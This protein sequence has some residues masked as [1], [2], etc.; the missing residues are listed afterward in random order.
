MLKKPLCLLALAFRAPL[1]LLS[2]PNRSCNRSALRSGHRGERRRHAD[3]RRRNPPRRH[4]RP[5]AD[6]NYPV[7]LT[8]TPYNKDNFAS[9]GQKGAA[10]GF[11]VVV[12]DVRGRF[13]SDGEWYPFKHEI[14]DGYDTVEW[15]AALPHSNSKVGMF[16]GSYVGA[17]QMLAAIGHPPHLAGICPVVTASNY[18]ENWTYQAAHSSS[19]ST[20]HG[21]QPWPKTRSTA[22]LRKRTMR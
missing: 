22:G 7:L 12:Q 19:G 4:L 21:P 9:F 16:S 5:A 20:S 13:T 15:A 18:H 11:M 10:R 2:G 8:R 1:H 3:P 6:S 17:T 14:E